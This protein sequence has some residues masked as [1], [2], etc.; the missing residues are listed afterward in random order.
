MAFTLSFGCS[1]NTVDMQH[2]EKVFQTSDIVALTVDVTIVAIALI[3]STVAITQIYGLAD[4]SQLS[5]F[6]FVGEHLSQLSHLGSFSKM[7]VALTIA[8][9]A[10]ITIIDL[11][12]IIVKEDSHIAGLAE[13]IGK[14][15]AQP[16]DEIPPG[17]AQLIA[18]ER[19]E[20]ADLKK[21]LNTD[22]QENATLR[23]QIDELNRELE[24]LK[25][26]QAEAADVA[27]AAPAPDAAKVEKLKQQIIQLQERLQTSDEGY[28]S[29]QAQLAKSEA[30]IASLKEQLTTTPKVSTLSAEITKNETNILDLQSQVARTQ[31][32][33]EEKEKELA[34]LK[35]FNENALAELRAELEEARASEVLL[36]KRVKVQHGVIES[37]KGNQEGAAPA[38]GKTGK[39]DIKSPTSSPE[40]GGENHSPRTPGSAGRG[41]L[42][43]RGSG[44]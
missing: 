4:L 42:R 32:H 38:P 41:E 9:A 20:V 1:S 16:S 40:K 33:L 27:G 29:I 6:G 26:Q 10:G 43:K 17:T 8:A 15:N 36:E 22:A 11:V 24:T 39:F 5:S 18:T 35:A 23:T 7:S 3:A 44:K 31:R 37:L 28:V 25:Q 12:C 14:T 2:P 13:E 19:R 21:R 30:T 34:K